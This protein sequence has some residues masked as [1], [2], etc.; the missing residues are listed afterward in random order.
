MVKLTGEEHEITKLKTIASSTSN[1]NGFVVKN[2]F[3]SASGN[4][5]QSSSDSAD[6]KLKGRDKNNSNRLLSDPI[7]GRYLQNKMSFSSISDVNQ[8]LFHIPASSSSS[9]NEVRVQKQK[10]VQATETL[11]GLTPTMLITNKLKD[12]VVVNNHQPCDQNSNNHD[13]VLFDN[14]MFASSSLKTFTSQIDST[15]RGS[16]YLESARDLH[17]NH[18]NQQKQEHTSNQQLHHQQQQQLQV[19]YC[20]QF[21]RLCQLCLITPLIGLVGCLCIACVFQFGDIQ[22]TACKVIATF[23][24]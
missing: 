14:S 9:S 18:D 24:L 2:N 8:Q 11:N 3:A 10:P 22:E 6:E 21:R 7:S 19:W 20:V 23:S 1:L 4:K 17:H 12:V 5:R 13:S 16:E 15:L